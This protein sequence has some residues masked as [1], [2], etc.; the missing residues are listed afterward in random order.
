MLPLQNYGRRGVLV[1]NVYSTAFVGQGLEV[2]FFPF[3]SDGKMLEKDFT[4][5]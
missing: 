3:F 2:V 5:R 1:E 4:I